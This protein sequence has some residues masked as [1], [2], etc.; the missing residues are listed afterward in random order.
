M[1][2]DIKIKKEYNFLKKDMIMYEKFI[3]P[4]CGNILSKYGNSLK[5]VRNHCFD[6]SSSGY[7]NLLTRGGKKGHG[8]DKKMVRARRDFLSKGYYS[9][10]R[11]AVKKMLRGKFN[12]NCALL[13]SGCGEGYYTNGFYDVLNE[14]TKNEVYG[15]DVSKEALKLAARLCPKVSFAAASAYCLPFEN[16]SFDIVTSVF[17]PL[18]AEEF[19]RVLKKGGRFITAIPLERHLFG[20]KQAVYEKPYLNKPENTRLDGFELTESAEVKKELL[21]ES[22]EDIKNL[23]MMTPYYYKTSAEDQKKL[24]NTE[25]LSTETEFLVLSYIKTL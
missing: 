8:D 1:T 25:K 19:Q 3:C 11:E 4:V 16:E 17:A 6:I 5:C 13:D 18:A 21:L 15:I 10:L 24:D 14:S 20:L 2:V 12:D 22:T 23:F 9:H 7:V